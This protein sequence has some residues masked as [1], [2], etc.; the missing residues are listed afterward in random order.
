MVDDEDFDFL[1]QWKWHHTKGYATRRKYFGKK[2]GKQ[3]FKDIY[4][5]RLLSK[6]PDGFLTDHVD[7]NGLNN[8]KKNLRHVTSSQNGMNTGLRKD[9]TSGY[10]GVWFDKSRKKWVAEIMVDR[11]KILIGRYRDIKVAINKRTE[12]EKIYFCF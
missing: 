7:R 5:H 10:K 4:M 3:I 11:K 6:T 2:N 8:R 1:N 9:N 12:A